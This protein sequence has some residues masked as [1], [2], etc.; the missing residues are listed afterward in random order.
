VLA[1]GELFILRDGNSRITEKKRDKKKNDKEK[2]REESKGGIDI[3]EYASCKHTKVGNRLKVAQSLCSNCLF[4]AL[5]GNNKVKMV[6]ECENKPCLIR[7]E[8]IKSVY[9]LF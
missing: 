1:N 9:Y 6:Y 2:K 5:P 8:K 7:V 4:K 3:T